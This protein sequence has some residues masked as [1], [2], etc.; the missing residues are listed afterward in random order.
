MTRKGWIE[1]LRVV[2]A[3][4]VVVTHVVSGTYDSPDFGTEMLSVSYGREILDL[5]FFRS[6][7][8]WAGPV[9]LMIS[10]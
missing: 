9:F 10:G 5:V 2:A 7:T 8:V 6:L 3:A 1:S 4:A